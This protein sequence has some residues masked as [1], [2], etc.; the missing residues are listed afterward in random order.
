MPDYNTVDATFM[1]F[2]AAKRWRCPRA[3]G[4]SRPRAGLLARLTDSIDWREE[5]LR[6]TGR[7][8]T[9][10]CA[11]DAY[12]QLT[13]MDARWA[14]GLSPPRRRA[15]GDRC[16][17]FNALMIAAEFG[18]CLA[19]EASSGSASWRARELLRGWLRHEEGGYGDVLT[20]SGLDTA[21]HQAIA[22]A[23]PYRS[24]TTPLSPLSGDGGEALRP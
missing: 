19:V 7:R 6:D 15:S 8:R 5:P 24:L 17:R 4:A 10:C 12:H 2:V 9:A 13:W 18:S 16:P 1:M 23:L 21:P 11:S 22:L 14:T 3:S 20:P